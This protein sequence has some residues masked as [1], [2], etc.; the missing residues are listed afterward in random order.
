MTSISKKQQVEQLIEERIST[1]LSVQERKDLATE[2][3]NIY[4][5]PV[6]GMAPTNDLLQDMNETFIK[7]HEIARKKNSDYGG[8]SDPYNNF[9]NTKIVGVSVQDGIMVRLTD[10]FSRIATLLKKK[11]EVSDE[12]IEDTINDAINYFA[13]LK[14]TLKRNIQ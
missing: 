5:S 11:A 7:C 8:G 4:E 9:R 13:I 12:S 1:R 14:S 2:I 3:K 6:K 10:K